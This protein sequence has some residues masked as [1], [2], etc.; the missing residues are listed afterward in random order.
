MLD[1][2]SGWLK[3]IITVILLASIVDLLLPNKAMQRYAR[4]VVGLI[5]LMTILSPLLKV[6]QGDFNTQVEAGMNEWEK[7][8]ARYD[9]RMPTLQD[10]TKEAQRLSEEQQ[11]QA[12]ALTERQ[13]AAAMELELNSRLSTQGTQVMVTLDSSG[14]SIDAV[15]VTLPITED[16]G[17]DSVQSSTSQDQMAIAPIKIAVDV[18]I[19]E[20]SDAAR[21]QQ[22]SASRE[23]PQVEPAVK[24]EIELA[25]R[26]GWSIAPDQ[27]VIRL[28]EA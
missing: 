14:K 11:R 18:D 16:Q 12:S 27:I 7:A 3:E 20:N 22:G 9:V 1:W 28:A 13:L 15:K 6:F 4:L 25:L 23:E 19:A 17:Q 26:Q 24:D 5:V 21:L 8:G 10:I 2:L